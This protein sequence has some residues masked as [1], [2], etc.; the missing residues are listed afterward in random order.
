MRYV[1][2]F[3]QELKQRKGLLIVIQ[4]TIWVEASIERVVLKAQEETRRSGIQE[5]QC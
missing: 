1:C 4:G 5:K 3:L 2:M